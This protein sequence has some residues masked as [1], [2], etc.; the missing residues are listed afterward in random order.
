M[1]RLVG[2]GFLTVLT[3]A[4]LLAAG[5]S[6]ALA[7]HVQCGDVVTQDTTLD[8]DLVDCPRNGIVVGAPGITLDLNGHMIDGDDSAGIE[9]C[10]VGILNGP[11]FSSACDDSNAPGHDDVTL[12]KGA[13]RQFDAGVV[14]SEASRN[15]LRGLTVSGSNYAAIILGDS[16][17]TSIE[18]N[19]LRNNRSFAGALNLFSAT[20]LRISGN[21]VSGSE[22]SGIETDGISD[23]WIERNSFLGNQ[24]GGFHLHGARNNLV[25]RNW[26]TGSET[27]IEIS[28]G[29]SD[30]R[31]VGNWVFGN[32]YIGIMTQEGARRNR[33]ERNFVFNNG[34][35]PSSDS[36][37]I[38]I[39]GD[40]NSARVEGNLVFGNHQGIVLADSSGANLIERNWVS[41]SVGDGIFLRDHNATNPSGADRVERNI[42]TR[43]GDD[44]IDVEGAVT[45]LT[46][47][48][49]NRN[50]D[51]GIE[52]VAGVTD[53]EG[54]RAFG[55]G[56]PLQCLNVV[57]R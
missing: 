41:R 57:C 30:N 22:G 50:G 1:P 10:G 38:L 34:S 26:V 6:P 7:S 3:V 25:E 45:N 32:S 23:S 12:R 31:V 4:S 49:A 37:G 40:G 44:G 19:L 15:R 52:A 11:T 28:D 53:G 13:V 55:N 39:L 14:V 46:G 35:V 27:G 33:I 36:S 48:H 43:N 17:E 8:S 51:L 2:P 18:R 29:V 24:Q 56:N 20:R 42:V 16:D 21:V 5:G 54:N 9:P 47:N